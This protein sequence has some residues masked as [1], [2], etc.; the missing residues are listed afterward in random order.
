MREENNN[1]TVG[2]DPH[3]DQRAVG[4]TIPADRSGWRHASAHGHRRPDVRRRQRQPD[5]TGQ[6][7]GCEMVAARRRASIRSTRRPSFAAAT[8]ST[9][10]R[11]TTRSPST[12]ANN[13][14]QVG[15]TKNTSCRR[16]RRPDRLADQPV[17]ER[18]RAADGSSLGL[19]D[20][21][22]H[23]TSATS[24][25]TAPR[26]A[27]SSTRSTSSASCPTRWRSRPATSARAAITCRSAARTT[28]REHQPARSE[29]P[30]A[31]H[32]ALNEQCRIRSSATPFAGRALDAGDDDARAAAAA[33]S[34]N[35]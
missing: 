16:P 13:Y 32:A 34:R 9:G 20:R 1:F 26:R 27:C 4:V 15:F 33:V 12:T 22:G 25:R 23:A 19:A 6:P 35:S 14:G 17:P 7:A 11:G 18:P 30:G 28:R 10:R 29:V 2:F 21:R 3:G 5:Q 24:I 8:G 31:R